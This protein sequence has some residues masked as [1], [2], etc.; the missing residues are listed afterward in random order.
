MMGIAAMIIAWTWT[1]YKKQRDNYEDSTLTQVYSVRAHIE[2]AL[3]SK[4]S[5]LRSYHLSEAEGHCR[6]AL[7][8]LG[9]GYLSIQSAE[10]EQKIEYDPQII[11]LHVQL[12]KICYLL[13]KYQSAIDNYLVCLKALT[14]EFGYKSTELI[15]P[16]RQISD[17]YMNL[18]QN[19]MSALFLERALKVIEENVIGD[20]DALLSNREYAP[21]CQQMAV[22]LRR[23]CKWKESIEF[24][25]KAI[26]GTYVVVCSM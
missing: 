23:Q 19:Q 20:G 10:N 9:G 17:C 11:A 4:D 3:Q 22:L 1:L 14:Q 8:D 12:G 18:G 6:K 16:C 21:I 7:Q 15:M 2:H 25:N 26:K 5:D 13:G 24:S